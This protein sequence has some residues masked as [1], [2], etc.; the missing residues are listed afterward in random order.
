MAEAFQA[1][2]TV[3]AIA[4]RGRGQSSKTA[5]HTVEDEGADV[6][7]VVDAIGAPVFLFGHAYG[8]LC[9]LEAALRSDR[10]EK[11]VLYEP[12]IPG[13]IPASFFVRADELA[14]KRDWDQMTEV[15]L[16]EII[17]VAPDDLSACGRRPSGT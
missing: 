9:S 12:P 8:A 17:E 3:Y 6:A 7:A 2:F 11:L 4:R 13:A 15:F 16:R 14:A 10:V 1:R 5:G